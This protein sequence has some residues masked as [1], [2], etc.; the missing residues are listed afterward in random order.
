MKKIWNVRK[1]K[2]AVSPVIATILMVAIT[3]VL[4][5]VLYAMVMIDPPP[6]PPQMGNIDSADLLTNTSVAICFGEFTGTAK[7]TELKLIL[8]DRNTDRIALTWSGIPDSED[9]GMR[10]SRQGVTATYRDWYPEGNEINVGDS[11][12]V[13]GLDLGQSY[14]IKLVTYEGVEIRTTGDTSFIIPE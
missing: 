5:A 8:E 12:V 14:E 6:P 11:V 13:A 7:P 9:Y 2:E 10:S 1:Q 4:A 3:V